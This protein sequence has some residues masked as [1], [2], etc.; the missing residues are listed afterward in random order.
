MSASR[1][2]L[3]RPFLGNRRMFFMRALYLAGCIWCSVRS[4]Q[5]SAQKSHTNGTALFEGGADDLNKGDCQADF[6]VFSVRKP[7]K[8]CGLPEFS[9]K[10]AKYTYENRVF[11]ALSPPPRTKGNCRAIPENDAR[12]WLP[13]AAGFFTEKSEDTVTRICR[14]LVCSC[15]LAILGSSYKLPFAVRPAD[16]RAFPEKSRK[17][18]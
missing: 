4:P 18:R 7:A 14:F 15:N 13:E 9:Q 1:K 12:L 10:S 8:G 3:T 16:G 6:S 17:Q 11:S 2:L 5:G